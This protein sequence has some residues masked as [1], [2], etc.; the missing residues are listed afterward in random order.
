M[1]TFFT[2]LAALLLSAFGG[3]LVAQQL[4]VQT[5]AQEEYIIVFAL[6]AIVAVVATALFFVA[7][8]RS[9]PAVAVASMA[10][11]L[12]VVYALFLL[13]LFGWSYVEAAGD[14]AKIYRDGGMIAGLVL[15]GVAI[16]LIQWLFVGWRVRHKPLT[17]FGREGV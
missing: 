11:I 3:S 7:Q 12:L 15:P 2:T 9:E 17:V 10:R 5:G 13:A 6:T 14:M 1:R 4:A 8:L 16:I